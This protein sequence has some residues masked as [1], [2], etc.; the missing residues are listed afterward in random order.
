MASLAFGGPL[1]SLADSVVLGAAAGWLS[2][3]TERC[4]RRPRGFVKCYSTHT[5][6]LRRPRIALPRTLSTLVRQN[7][8]VVR[9]I[10]RPSAHTHHMTHAT[11]YSGTAHS[12]A[13]YS[14]EGSAVADG[15]PAA[16]SGASSI[17]VSPPPPASGCCTASAACAAAAA[18]AGSAP[19]AS[20][21]AAAAGVSPSAAAAAAAS[22][23]SC[24]PAACFDRLSFFSFFSFLAFFSLLPS[25]RGVV[26]KRQGARSVQSQDGQSWCWTGV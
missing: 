20:S 22:P 19:A 15:A 7:L 5:R 8:R 16:A 21:A 12:R 10:T 6:S 2:T 18:A 23:P 4:Q 3:F 24:L 17:A 11:P 1:A 9:S 25:L 14:A 26:L 13:A